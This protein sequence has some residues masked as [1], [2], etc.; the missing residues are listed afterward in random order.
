MIWSTIAR[1]SAP[2]R[3]RRSSGSDPAGLTPGQFAKGF[4]TPLGTLRDWEQHRTVPAQAA[5]AYLKLI[6]ADPASWS[7][8]PAAID[9]DWAAVE[10]VTIPNQ[11]K[12]RSD[13]WSDPMRVTSVFGEMQTQ[14]GAAGQTRNV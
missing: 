10:D 5:R 4:R 9:D 2:A 11:M 13:P 6:A 1:T 8:T 14:T 12:S 7:A 3:G